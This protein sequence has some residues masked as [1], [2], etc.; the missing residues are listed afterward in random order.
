MKKSIWI[1][2]SLV[3]L[4]TYKFFNYGNFRLDNMILFLS[5]SIPFLIIG[6]GAALKQ[7][8]LDKI[9]LPLLILFFLTYIPSIIT[10]FFGEHSREALTNLIFRGRENA[11]L[12]HLWPFLAALILISWGIYKT[13]RPR[14]FFRKSLFLIWSLLLIFIFLSG[15]M[16]GIFFIL[17][18]ITFI[19]IFNINFSKFLNNSLIFI[20]FIF[21][22]YFLLI[23]YASGPTLAKVSGIGLLIQSGFE[24]NDEILNILTSSR[25]FTFL[26]SINQF[27][28]KPFFGHG[29]Y[30]ESV[31]GML[32]N[33]ESFITASGGHNFFIDLAAFMGV[34]SIPLILVY[35][36]FIKVSRQ[37]SK[38]TAGTNLH[39]LNVIIYSVFVA[40]F[41]SNILNHWLLFSPFDNFIFLLAGYIYGQLYFVSKAGEAITNSRQ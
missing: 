16:S 18:S 36:N 35:Y 3:I 14:F 29:V 26:H 21:S 15:Y 1:L 4:I 11:G 13:N 12:I 33:V 23:T 7:K 24:F 27:L 2:L 34:F 39:G 22:S 37:V 10:Y 25:W 32:K 20:S 31:D 17:T 41:I 19:Y 28:E 40:V 8:D 6:Y 9:V 30:L 38:L 5:I